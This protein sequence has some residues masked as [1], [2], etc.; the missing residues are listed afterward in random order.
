M[1]RLLLFVAVLFLAPVA[2]QAQWA[3]DGA[4]PDETTHTVPIHGLAV[5]PDGKVWI[6][7]F[8]ATEQI[9]T[10][11]DTLNVRGIYC[12]EQ[13]G[14]PCS[15]SPIKMITVAGVTDTLFNSSRGLGYLPNG[16]ILH[17]SFDKLYVIDYQTG[18]GV[19]AVLPEADNS[20]S[21]PRSDGNGNIYTGLVVPGVGPLRVFDGD[22][23]F[24]E[25][26]VDTTRGFSRSF[27]V[28]EDGLSIY[29][30]GYT[31]R[32]IWKYTRPDEFSPFDP[33][34]TPIHEGIVTESMERHPLTGNIW[35]SNA[36]AA[37]SFAPWGR[38]NADTTGVTYLTWYELDKDTDEIV[39]SL[40]WDRTAGYVDEKP[41]GIS[42]SWDG[43]YA[44]A[45]VFDATSGASSVQRFKNMGGSIAVE[46]QEVVPSRYTLDQNYPNPFN[47]STTIQ[48]GLTEAA[49]AR[50]TVYDALGRTVE[51]LVDQFLTPGTY[52][53]PFDAGSLPS[54]TYLYTLEANGQRM[55]R[56]MLLMK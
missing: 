51:V 52:S 22:L 21:A 33:T 32:A 6:T 24:L 37:G 2:A 26:A 3:F 20:L 10:E 48:F 27:G 13:D 45:A 8:S 41:R 16:N 49:Q 35:A 1:K 43:M 55:S 25:N 17:A 31:L 12:Y 42:F 47:P 29:W 44:Y 40:V 4:F 54:G 46:R 34:P 53:A 11:T 23:N 5:D 7:P 50:L 30:V 36:M 28:S 19:A 39:D 14:T 56:T 15:F 38:F 9:F 18:E